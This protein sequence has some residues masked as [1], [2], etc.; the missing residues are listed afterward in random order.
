MEPNINIS[1][2]KMLELY[3]NLESVLDKI[4]PN[5]L[6]SREFISGLEESLD[7]IKKRQVK[8]VDT[9]EDFLS[10]EKF[11]KLLNSQKI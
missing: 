8:N 5:K 11:L 6:Y 2:E 4:A 1:I 9:I 3:L 7:D 10:W